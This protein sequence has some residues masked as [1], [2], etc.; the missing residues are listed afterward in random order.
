MVLTLL[1]EVIA[2]HVGPTAVA[3]WGLGLEL[4]S[5]STFR[6]LE[7]GLDDSI[8]VLLAVAISARILENGKK[9]SLMRSG[10]NF[11]RSRRGFGGL[12][13]SRSLGGAWFV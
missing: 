7:E 11:R 9:G 4:V 6:V 10:R 5:R 1:T 8:Q 12:G 2:F 3:V 13:S